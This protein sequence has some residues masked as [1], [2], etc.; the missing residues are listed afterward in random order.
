QE[1]FDAAFELTCRDLCFLYGT[2]R[3]VPSHLSEA[4]DKRKREVPRPIAHK[5]CLDG[6]KAGLAATN[7]LINEKI[8]AV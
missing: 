6:F 5:A 2:S 4:C 7:R 1:G 3:A 8:E